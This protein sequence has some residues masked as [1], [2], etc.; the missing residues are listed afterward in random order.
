M[1]ISDNWL[2]II[3]HLAVIGDMDAVNAVILGDI[4]TAKRAEAWDEFVGEVIA[5]YGANFTVRLTDGS[6]VGWDNDAFQWAVADPDT[7]AEID[8]SISDEN[9]ATLREEANEHGD[10]L[11][12]DICDLALAGDADARY[13]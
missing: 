11:T 5:D 7:V 4:E 10:M 12:V 2:P 6:V 1:T 3:Y 8:K 13:E 9:I